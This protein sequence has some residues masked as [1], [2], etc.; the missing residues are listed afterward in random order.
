MIE[1][2]KVEKVYERLMTLLSIIVDKWN[3]KDKLKLYGYLIAELMDKK[4][5]IEAKK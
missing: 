3:K 4:T 5:I 2:T 1:I